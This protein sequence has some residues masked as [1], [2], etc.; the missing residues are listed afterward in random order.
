MQ[1][2]LTGKL[3]EIFES[4]QGEGLYCGCRQ[5]FIRLHGCNLH[6]S[7]CDTAASTEPKS[8]RSVT[9]HQLALLCRGFTS[10]DISF[11][12][13]EPLLQV[14]FLKQLIVELRQVG[15]FRYHLETNG[16]L[17]PQLMRIRG[18]LDVVALDIKLP[19]TA[20][21]GDLWSQHRDFLA[22]CPAGKVFVKVVIGSDT[23]LS[24]IERAAQLVQDIDRDIPMVMQPV[25]GQGTISQEKL[26]DMQLSALEY[27]ADVRIIPQ[28]HKILGVR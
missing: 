25:T 5:I 12:G 28:C 18:S 13:G 17:V 15:N 14:D 21:A 6:C 7:Y 16:T 4:I 26:M 1:Q 3:V 20:K 22:A 2:I 23:D 24:E 10:N 9:A 11:T 19:S 27:L 8:Y